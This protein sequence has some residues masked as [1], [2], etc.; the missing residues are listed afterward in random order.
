MKKFSFQ[1]FSALSL[2]SAVML[3]GSTIFA[4]P[5]QPAP[6]LEVRP[7]QGNATPT[8]ES[9]Y[10]YTTRVKNIGNQTAQSVTIMVEFPLTNTSPTKHIL[11]NLSGVSASSGTCSTANNKITCSVGNIGINQTKYVTFTFEFQVATTPP[12]LKTTVSTASNN[13]QDPNNNWRSFTPAIAYPNNQITAGSYLVS[14]C[15]GRGLTSF[16]ECEKSPSSIQSE[17]VLDFDLGGTVSVNGY[18]QYMG[19]WDQLAMPD[20]SLHFTITGELEFNGFASSGTCYKGIT[21]FP[22]TTVYNSAYRVCR[23]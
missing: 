21:T 16:Y 13:E 10:V 9:P 15:T 20:R 2:L 11:G 3:L 5:P 17:L 8:V 22:S 1:S 19:F 14:S 7:W 23:Q 6:N 18:P 12:T 4:A